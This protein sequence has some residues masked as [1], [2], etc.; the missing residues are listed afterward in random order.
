[1][2]TQTN[3]NINGND[4]VTPA[5][6]S[7]IKAMSDVDEKAKE[8][9]KTN[10]RTAQKSTNA[11]SGLTR[12]FT[13][14]LPR[15]LQKVIRSFTST[16][17]AVSRASKTFKVLRGAIISTGIGA[18]VVALGLLIENWEKITKLLSGVTEEQ[19]KYN[20]TIQAGSQAVEDYNYRNQEYI[21]IVNDVTAST[22]LREQAL[23]NLSKTIKEAQG[24][25]VD[26]AEDLKRLNIATERHTHLLR[27]RGEQEEMLKQV[28]ELRKERDEQKLNLL[29]L[30]AGEEGR[31][32]YLAEKKAVFDEKINDLLERYNGLQGDRLGL[33][34]EVQDELERQAK[35]KADIK[36]AEAESA[37]AE[38]EAKRV[39]EDAE[40]KRIQDAEF[41]ADRLLKIQE[42]MHL[43]MIEDDIMQQKERRRL[44]YLAD[45]ADLEARN[46]SF[47]QLLALKQQYDMDIAEID[48]RVE[49]EKAR[50]EKERL[51]KEARLKEEFRQKTLTEKQLE[52]EEALAEFQRQEELAGTNDALVLEAFEAFQMQKEAINEKYN[53]QEID[54]N[55]EVIDLEIE[56]RQALAKGVSGLFNQMGKLAEQNS[57]EQKALA[58]ADVL[59]NQ[60]VAMANAIRSASKTA[61]DPISLGVLITTMV[62]GVLSSFASIKGI[63]NQAQAGGG[64]SVGGGG[65]GGQTRSTFQD[66]NTAPLP[67]RMS[68]PDAQAY[69]VQSQLEGQSMMS[70][71]VRQKSTL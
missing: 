27:L 61:K 3:I 57:K 46:A 59:L 8:T 67:A 66:L 33:E 15:G 20:A 13:Q 47:L 64:G 22:D 62:G 1:M 36:A 12:V 42:S 19:E 30:M 60:A 21:D 44:Q 70:E 40:R 45:Q 23:L 28:A 41:L 52:E 48:G 31:A 35:E 16:Q 2:S 34:K 6:E 18:L 26:S 38:A 9:A 37:R 55:Q 56:G 63:L 53:Q 5:A 10:R 50:K 43:A 25:D 54:A 39:R 7:A 17:K 71:Q 68:T 58:V 29:E 4:R 24:L 32:Q 69:V 14:F 51:D 49:D 65:G 11:W